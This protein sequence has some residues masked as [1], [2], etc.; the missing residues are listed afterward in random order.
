MGR[1]L[2]VADTV[3]VD[4]VLSLVAPILHFYRVLQSQ[5]LQFLVRNT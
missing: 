3:G 5:L 4:S 1:H 2:D